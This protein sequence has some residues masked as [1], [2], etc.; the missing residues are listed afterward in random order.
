MGPDTEGLLGLTRAFQ[1][2]G[3]RSVLA[4]LWAVPDRTTVE[5]MGTF[6]EGLRRGLAKDEALR[7]A[8]RAAIRKGG[9]GSRPFRWAGFQLFGDWK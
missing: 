3:A 8:Q 2:A 9:V 7:Q 6:Y 1:Y 4:S 5:L